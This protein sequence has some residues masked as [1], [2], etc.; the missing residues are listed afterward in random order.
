[1][2]TTDFDNEIHE[3]LASDPVPEHAP[4]FYA[5]LEIK[6]ASEAAQP[7]VGIL[8]PGRY[9]FGA[10]VTAAAVVAA[11]AL[12]AETSVKPTS[13]SDVAAP[14]TTVAP[15][16]SSTAPAVEEPRLTLASQL[17]ERA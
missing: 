11:I 9:W 8:R 3:L 4:E 5:Q 2:S 7:K 12:V 10:L 1:M 13:K 16:T 6:L 17:V 14:T 15:S